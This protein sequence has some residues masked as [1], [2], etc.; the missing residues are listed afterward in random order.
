MSVKF[1]SLVAIISVFLFFGSCKRYNSDEVN[2][3]MIQGKW[4]LVAVESKKNDSAGLALNQQDVYLYFNGNKCTQEI[5][6]L[7][8]SDYTFTIHNYT[9]MLYKDSIFDNKLDI[10]T[11]TVDSLVFKQGGSRSLKYKRTGQ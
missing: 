7:V 3:Q 6:G 5:V 8:K 2:N 11:L 1:L 9:L 10:Y 4:Q